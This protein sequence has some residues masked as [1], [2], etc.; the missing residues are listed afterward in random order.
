MGVLEKFIASQAKGLVEKTQPAAEVEMS[1][2][3][4]HFDVTVTEIDGERE[5]P[6]TFSVEVEAPDARTAAYFA[7][8]E[9]LALTQ[10][11]AE[12]RAAMA[13]TAQKI[14]DRFAALDEAGEGQ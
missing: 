6:F 1:S 13:Y 10:K 9:L 11:G 12:P 4:V 5:L 14:A 2:W 3:S 8:G 7:A